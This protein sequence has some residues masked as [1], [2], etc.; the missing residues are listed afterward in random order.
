MTIPCFPLSLDELE[1]QYSPVP[2]DRNAAVQL[3]PLLS[4]FPKIQIQT[5]EVRTRPSRSALTADEE[6]AAIF[7]DTAFQ[8]ELQLIHDLLDLPD[9]WIADWKTNFDFGGSAYFAEEWL[10]RIAE[11]QI[12]RGQVAAGISRLIDAFKLA[13]I[14]G[15]TPGSIAPLLKLYRCDQA[16]KAAEVLV[17]LR[18]L[19][20]QAL[21]S[22]DRQVESLLERHD[23]ARSIQYGLLFEDSIFNQKNGRYKSV[24]PKLF[25]ENLQW[26]FRD[27]FYVISGRSTAD[28][29]DLL[30]LNS[31]H[32][33]LAKRSTSELIGSWTLPEGGAPLPPLRPKWDPYGSLRG[34][35]SQRWIWIRRE[36]VLRTRALLTHVALAVE[37]Y[38]RDHQE[39]PPDSLDALV[40]NYLSAVP[41]DSFGN[42]PLHY[43]R[44]P[45]AFASTVSAPTSGTTV[46]CR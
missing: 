3:L 38:R 43:Q 2:D 37:R 19:P 26:R 44:L 4:R 30:R 18:P 24:R 12:N 10:V 34:L 25:L 23:V 33:E 39:Q 11:A 20:R 13:D 36:A 15:K 5:A 17:N 6:E 14:P 28:R 31:T 22:L 1:N 40:P 9:F 7:V 8:Q 45:S 16:A 32:L 46:A 35:S 27:F 29:L 41:A 42:G 21:D